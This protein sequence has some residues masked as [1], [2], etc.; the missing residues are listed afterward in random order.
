MKID[1]ILKIF[2]NVLKE[3]NNEWA[4]ITDDV[5]P[6]IINTFKIS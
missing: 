4:I 3:Y 6:L 1:K 5:L 2:I